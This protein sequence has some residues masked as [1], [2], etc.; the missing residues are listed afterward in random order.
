M[1][2][3]MI[4]IER[5]YGSGGLEI[6]Q[7]LAEDLKVPCYG[8]EIL[9]TV[10]KNRGTTAEQLI[11]MEEKATNSVLYSMAMA[12]RMATG[13]SDGLSEE[14]E[15][16]LEEAKVIKEKAG[17]GPCVFVGRCASW[18]LRDR[19][20]VLNVFIHADTEFR[21]KRAVESYGDE[22]G[23]IDSLL[24]RC[25]KRRNSYYAANTGKRWDDKRGYHIILDSG[26]LGIDRCV[27]IICT[28]LK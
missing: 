13:L 27:E 18:V 11:H 12:A 22:P 28:G 1:K 15:L 26:R 25:D 21:E 10:A 14:S 7:K 4:T 2:Y 17:L 8:K 19:K 24:K 23:K 5:E 20:D 16:Y 9:E 6:G 3:S